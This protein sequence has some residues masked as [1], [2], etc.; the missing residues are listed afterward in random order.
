[1]FRRTTYL[2]DS[3]LQIRIFLRFLMMVTFA[4]V[5]AGV[6]T[7]WYAHRQEKLNHA[8]LYYVTNTM[9]EDPKKMSQT[10]IILPA[11][12]ISEAVMIVVTA[13]FALFYSHRIAG[14]V[15]R[16]KKAMEEVSQGNMD[17]Q[18]KIRK[19]DEF[20]D[21]AENFNAMLKNVKEKPS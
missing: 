14:P 4:A 7:I 10:D 11:L 20:H 6:V 5:L 16:L 21:L 12:A 17:I 3:G 9:G 1:M 13:L 15:Y 2:I 18:V 19:N 8:S